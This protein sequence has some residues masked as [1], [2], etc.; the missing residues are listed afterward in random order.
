VRVVLTD[1]LL[2]RRLGEWHERRRN[3]SP[4]P[5]IVWAVESGIQSEFIHPFPG[6]TDLRVL[7]FEATS[8]FSAPAR[9]TRPDCLLPPRKSPLG[10]CERYDAFSKDVL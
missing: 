5:A 8:D 10:A 2:L 9:G 7:V 1:P 3:E 4:S 6:V